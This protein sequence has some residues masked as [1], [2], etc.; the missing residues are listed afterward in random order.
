MAHVQVSAQPA[1]SAVTVA[2][3]GNVDERSATALAAVI[4]R[5]VNSRRVRVLIVDLAGVRLV[6]T[7]APALRQAVEGRREVDRF[8]VLRGPS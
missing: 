5:V 1:T 8:V 4:D 3:S 7:S 2:V 6:G